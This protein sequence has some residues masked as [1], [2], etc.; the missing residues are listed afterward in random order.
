MSAEVSNQE[1]QRRFELTL[2]GDVTHARENE[3]L[4]DLKRETIEGVKYGDVQDFI[5]EHARDVQRVL[6]EWFTRPSKDGTSKSQGL[7]KQIWEHDVTFFC[8]DPAIKKKGR[9]G[10]HTRVFSIKDRDTTPC[11]GC[12]RPYAEIRSKEDH[13]L[14]KASKS[15][16][17]SIL[18]SARAYTYRSYPVE[19]SEK[20]GKAPKRPNLIHTLDLLNLTTDSKKK[21]KVGLNEARDYARHLQ[22]YRSQLV[23]DV[24]LWHDPKNEDDLIIVVDVNFA[25]GYKARLG[26]CVDHLAGR[27]RAFLEDEKVD[28]KSGTDR[29]YQ[30]LALSLVLIVG[31][32]S[33]KPELE[34]DWGFRIENADSKWLPSDASPEEFERTNAGTQ[35]SETNMMELKGSIVKKLKKFEN[36]GRVLPSNRLLGIFRR[37]QRKWMYC[38]PR[39]H[40]LEDGKVQFRGYLTEKMA[41]QCSIIANHKALD[42]HLQKVGMD[43]HIPKVSPDALDALNHLQRTAWR[44]NKKVTEAAS[45]CLLAKGMDDF[46]EFS[47]ISTRLHWCRSFVK[48]GDDFYHVWQFDHRGRMYPLYP[49]LSPQGD[50]LARGLLRFAQPRPLTE[51]GWY[52]MKLRFAELWHFGTREDS[53]DAMVEKVD[54]FLA[55][56]A[57]FEKDLEKGEPGWSEDLLTHISALRT[58]IEAEVAKEDE[59]QLTVWGTESAIQAWGAGQEFT[60]GSESF[61]RLAVTI[62]V[63]KIFSKLAGDYSAKRLNEVLTDLPLHHDASANVYQHLAALFRDATLASQVNILPAEGSGPRGD[64]YQFVADALDSDPNPIWDG[65]RNHHKI[66]HEVASVLARRSVA[67]IPVMTRAYG[68]KVGPN[69]FLSKNGASKGGIEFT[70]RRAPLTM[71][72]RLS[73][74][75]MEDADGVLLRKREFLSCQICEFEILWRVEYADSR[76]SVPIAKK[77][78]EK[79]FR[80]HLSERHGVIS[81]EINIPIWSE[82]GPRYTCYK[83]KP[84]ADIN[85][86]ELTL[87][88]FLS[89]YHESHEMAPKFH[90]E[91]HIARLFEE[92]H[93]NLMPPTRDHQEWASRLSED[94]VA[95]MQQTLPVYEKYDRICRALID[96]KPAL[97]WQTWDE[98]GVSNVRFD[99]TSSTLTATSRLKREKD[100]MLDQ[101]RKNWPGDPPATINVSTRK[102]D[103]DLRK[104]LFEDLKVDT[105]DL[106][107]VRPG[108]KI[109]VARGN[110]RTIKLRK[111]CPGSELARAVLDYKESVLSST[112]SQRTFKSEPDE[113]KSLRGLRPDFIHALDAS[114]LRAVIL[115]QH[116]RWIADPDSIENRDFWAVH[117]CFGG[118]PS[119]IDQIRLDV[120]DQFIEIHR[121]PILL[122]FIEKILSSEDSVPSFLE[123]ADVEIPDENGIDWDM[124]AQLD[125]KTG[126]TSSYMVG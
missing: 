57:K 34:L 35:R 47:K 7:L 102:F 23:E 51:R 17:L 91:S 123:R 36:D 104:A 113:N 66:F 96:V 99:S 6:T 101:I 11:H 84:K 30:T 54:R 45:L 9:C 58:M 70:E 111:N 60:R 122:N 50:D 108:G 40:V 82:H 5:E 46:L 112:L 75:V 65:S 67:K 94:Y 98:F 26:E 92:V 42:K 16:V 10:S 125:E 95:A 31:R 68:S 49:E 115:K 44:V 3:Q 93:P 85:A 59:A 74:R 62:E 69:H 121:E 48:R 87:E 19:S 97:N 8:K 25:G 71:N 52:W 53:R 114:H 77:E 18:S 86:R 81:G 1:Y 76:K 83:C 38:K 78:V 22:M 79:A 14:W 88:E 41:K 89:H 100:E 116:L 32:A 117:D 15:I 13:H 106:A 4:E 27:L 39:D 64:I 126:L 63:S 20:P 109:S 28:A 124:A 37:A 103:H 118:H 24:P 61:Q 55:N 90:P 110:L 120:V 73:K 107:E 43:D 2:L 56:P 21:V 72:Y 80:K 33:E 119:Q 29:Q 12:K 105:T